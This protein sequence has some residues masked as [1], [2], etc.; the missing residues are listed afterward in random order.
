MF[1]SYSLIELRVQFV[2]EILSKEF[3]SKRM[4][5]GEE[6]Y[7]ELSCSRKH[8]L[9]KFSRE[10]IIEKLKPL[11]NT[12]LFSQCRKRGNCAIIAF[13]NCNSSEEDV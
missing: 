13:V 7:Y 1:L 8:W 10:K 6:N 2:L 11:I 4:K 3:F 5:N 9:P 12:I